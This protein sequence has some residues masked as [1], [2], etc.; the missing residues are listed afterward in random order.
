MISPPKAVIKTLQQLKGAGFEAWLVGGCVRDRL[1][2]RPIHDWDIATSARPEEVMGLFLKTIPTGLKH[3]TV[4]VIQGKLPL[5][6]T[7][8]RVDMGYSDGR[9]P[10]LVLYTKQL[11][12][13][14]ARRDFSVNAMAWDPIED[15][16]SDPFG[17]RGD[18]EEKLLRA[19][20]RAEE[21]F[22]EDGLR[23]FR[24]VRFAT[25]LNFRLDPET[26]AAIPDALP[27]AA[28]VA[29]ERV[30]AELFKILEAPEAAQGLALL[31]ISG[32]LK[33]CLPELEGCEEWISLLKGIARLKEP[34]LRLT[35]L[36]SPL[37]DPE[38]TL[39][40]L[41]FSREEIK[42]VL[43]ILEHWSLDPAAPREDAELRALVAQ[44][45]PKLPLLISLRCA[46]TPSQ[47]AP[48][49]RLLERSRS[50]NAH[51]A[52]RSVRELALNGKQVMDQLQ[53]RPSPRLGRILE[54]LLQRVWAEPELNTFEGLSALLPEVAA[55]MPER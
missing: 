20:G 4:T 3:G 51:A 14:L 45:G 29:V 30:R 35:L 12:E 50:L 9:R 24:A 22:A 54:A 53:L 38:A 41:R 31:K 37:A 40:R 47:R 34:L 39:R 28:K 44:A 13:D 10:D 15:R 6:I 52:P 7:T 33:I 16:F 46:L 25:T 5:E 36:L 49:R 18:L 19:V 17:G 27:I 43:G 42:M 32:L 21:R 55:Q 26:L 2:M 11:E 23:A 48:W 1:L 8:F